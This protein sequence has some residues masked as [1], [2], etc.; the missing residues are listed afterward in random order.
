MKSKGIHKT[1]QEKL[2]MSTKPPSVIDTE[3]PWLEYFFHTESK[4][5][6]IPVK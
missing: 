6:I 1:T 4:T 3:I 5:F 2:S